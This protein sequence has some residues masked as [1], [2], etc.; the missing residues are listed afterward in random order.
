MQPCGLLWGRKALACILPTTPQGSG[1]PAV[2]GPRRRGEAGTAAVWARRASGGAQ[3]GRPSLP[4]WSPSRVLRP[5]GRPGFVPLR[6]EGAAGACGVRELGA[7]GPRGAG[8][9]AA[10]SGRSPGRA[11]R[12]RDRRTLDSRQELVALRSPAPAPTSRGPRKKPGTFP[13]ASCAAWHQVRTQGSPRST[14][15]PGGGDRLRDS[16]LLANHSPLLCLAS[17]T[18]CLPLEKSVPI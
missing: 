13:R 3:A 10:E 7:Q 6:R 16:R 17:R 9:Q 12:H 2:P 18:A 15:L 14:P 5:V 8:R 1:E 4:R 11:H